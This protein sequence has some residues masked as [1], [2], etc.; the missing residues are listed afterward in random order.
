MRTLYALLERFG[1][2]FLFLFLEII[3]FYLVVNFNEKQNLILISSANR[4]A[5]STYQRIND[6]RGYFNLSNVADSLAREN[7]YL[8]TLIKNHELNKEL[9]KDSVTSETL[10][11]SYHYVAARII[12]KSIHRHNNSITL[13]RGTKDGI[14][15]HSGV[16]S[17]KG[18]VGIVLKAS[19]NYAQVMPLLH[20]QAKI[21]AGI[22]G[23]GYFGSLVWQGS[24]PR[25][26]RLLDIPKYIEVQVGDTIQTT[27]YSTYFPTA[28]PIGRVDTTWSE[29]N[30]D[31]QNIR[32]R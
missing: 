3:A 2:F 10:N 6:V 13:N 26:M 16:I 24:D 5:G 20:R 25:Y 27:G 22:R 28:I 1:T 32:V 18:I 17:D 21:S 4:V 19:K 23:K 15:P 7:A 12:N 11:Q 29:S 8:R 14:Q 30:G 9:P 31:F